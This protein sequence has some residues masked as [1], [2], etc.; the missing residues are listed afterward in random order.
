VIQNVEREHVVDPARVAKYPVAP[1]KSV[2][3]DLAQLVF[4]VEFTYG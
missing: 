1:E 4:V 2:L 3:L